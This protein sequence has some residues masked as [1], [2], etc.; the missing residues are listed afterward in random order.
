MKIG[1]QK[2]SIITRVQEAGIWIS[3]RPAFFNGS[4]ALKSGNLGLGRKQGSFKA[5][6][7]AGKRWFLGL[8]ER[9]GRP[10]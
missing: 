4:S 1:N 7:L 2:T 10:C 6:F 8:G 3:E 9:E 5:P